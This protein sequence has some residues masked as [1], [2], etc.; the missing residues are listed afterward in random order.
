[1]GVRALGVLGAGTM[2]AG[3]A[4][5]GALGG[6]ETRVYDALPGA[7]EKGVERLRAALERGTARGRWSEAEAEAAGGRVRP[8]A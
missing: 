5:I 7:A 1:M 4:Q 6:Y 2:G 3:I 8:V